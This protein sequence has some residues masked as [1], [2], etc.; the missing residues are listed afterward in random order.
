MKRAFVFGQILLSPTFTSKQE[1]ESI[2]QNDDYVDVLS[3]FLVSGSL[4]S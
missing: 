4:V 1:N 3:G 2:K